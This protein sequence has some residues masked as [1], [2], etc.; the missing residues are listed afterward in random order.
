M[1][2]VSDVTAELDAAQEAGHDASVR[3]GTDGSQPVQADMRPSET[4]DHIEA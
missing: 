2:F 4:F 3:P 1:L